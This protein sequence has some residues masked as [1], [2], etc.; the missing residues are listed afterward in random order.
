MIFRYTFEE[1]LFLIYNKKKPH[2]RE[3]PAGEATYKI[4]RGRA[5]TPAA[6]T[7]GTL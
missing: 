6:R 7:G 3:G 2:S 4:N 1:S 5:F